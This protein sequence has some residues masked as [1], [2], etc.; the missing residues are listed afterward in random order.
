VNDLDLETASTIVQQLE[1][2]L[3]V[4]REE[5]R[6]LQIFYC[7]TTLHLADANSWLFPPFMPY[8]DDAGIGQMMSQVVAS[9]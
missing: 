7:I 4:I 5:S 3:G 9:A 6:K 8:L 2:I 1:E